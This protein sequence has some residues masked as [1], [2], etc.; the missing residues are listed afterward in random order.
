MI[1]LCNEMKSTKRKGEITLTPHVGWTEMM[2]WM[3]FW[4]LKVPI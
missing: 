1:P 2:D 3:F 4:E